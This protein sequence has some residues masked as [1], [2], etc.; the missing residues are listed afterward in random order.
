MARD[1]RS[2]R[3]SGAHYK[4]MGGPVSV[5]VR[6][7]GGCIPEGGEHSPRVPQITFYQLGSVG[8]GCR[9][10]NGAVVPFVNEPADQGQKRCH[11]A[12]GRGLLLLLCDTGL[13][14][15]CL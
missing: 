6:Q 2:E 12:I 10:T 9:L 15:F 13:S 3:E 11:L 8:S 7:D 4:F 14:K 1:E 5:G